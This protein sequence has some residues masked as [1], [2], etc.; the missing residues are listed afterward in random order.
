MYNS[1]TNINEQLKAV[2]GLHQNLMNMMN[3]KLNK[4]S[5]GN[6]ESSFDPKNSTMFM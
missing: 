2:L 3:P 6:V 1:Q 5:G 4:T